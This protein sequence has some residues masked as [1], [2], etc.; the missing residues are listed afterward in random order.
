MEQRYSMNFFLEDY[1]GKSEPEIEAFYL[2]DGDNIFG[3]RE[4][5]LEDRKITYYFFPIDSREALMFLYVGDDIFDEAVDSLDKYNE[6]GVMNAFP[7]FAQALIN[8]ANDN[9]SKTALIKLPHVNGRD[10]FWCFATKIE[11]VD[12]DDLENEYVINKLQ[13]LLSDTINV[14]NQ[15]EEND[16]STW[17]KLKGAGKAGFDG[18]RLAKAALTIGGLF[19]GVDLSGGD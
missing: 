13:K 15:L 6:E 10:S 3:G 17:D 2:E 14:F 18:W 16:I 11:N 9:Y 19:F 12:F 7:L 4:L 5:L 1:C 8:G